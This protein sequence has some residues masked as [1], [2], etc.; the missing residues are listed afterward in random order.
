ML[1]ASPRGSKMVIRNPSS[2]IRRLAKESVMETRQ[3]ASQLNP[4]NIGLSADSVLDRV[5]IFDHLTPKKQ[6]LLFEAKRF[7]E[8]TQYR[9]CWAKSSTIYLRKNEGSR[10]I[11]ITDIGN[12]RRPASETLHYQLDKYL[13]VN[14]PSSIH[15]CM[16]TIR[17]LGI[18][19]L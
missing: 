6:D 4:P 2:I 1:T 10:P 18:F 16:L 12:L 8:Q 19:C 7:K 17:T 15:E 13:S 9:S 14:N 11:K 5:R 3:S